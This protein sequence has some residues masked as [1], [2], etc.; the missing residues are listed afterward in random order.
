MYYDV[1]SSSYPAISTLRESVDKASNQ[2]CMDAILNSFYVD[3]FLGGASSGEAVALF[4]DITTT[5]C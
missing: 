2:T 5:F 3:D 4:K 1:A